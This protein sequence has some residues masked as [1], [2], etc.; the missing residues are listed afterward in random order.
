VFSA[1]LLTAL[2]V[3]RDV[4]IQ[5]YLLTGKYMLAADSIGKTTADLQRSS[6]ALGL[7][8]PENILLNTTAGI[9]LLVASL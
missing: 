6:R 9:G 2:G 8:P 1:I 4:V 3:P 5:D 7:R